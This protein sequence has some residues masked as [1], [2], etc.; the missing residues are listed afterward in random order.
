MTAESLQ[1]KN[2]VKIIEKDCSDA[3]ESHSKLSIGRLH[4]TLTQFISDAS[5][6]SYYIKKR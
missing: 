3:L 5:V 1:L 2:L 6:V 4:M